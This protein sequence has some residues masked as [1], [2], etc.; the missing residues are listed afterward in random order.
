MRDQR[1]SAI[2]RSVKKLDALWT[3]S[4]LST[5]LERVS[6]SLMRRP[7]T[8]DPCRAFVSFS[9]KRQRSVRRRISPPASLS[10][11]CERLLHQGRQPA[12]QEFKVKEAYLKEPNLS[13]QIKEPKSRS[14]IT[15][16]QSQGNIS[17]EA[18]V[19]EPYLK[20]PRSR[21]QSTRNQSQGKKPKSTKQ[22]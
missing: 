19:K 6:E 14:Q 10:S 1:R 12:S 11:C 4:L 5:S 15:R 18:K 13:S 21:K 9:K 3:S 8:E 16:K 22:I 2:E 7:Q 20:K 17:Q